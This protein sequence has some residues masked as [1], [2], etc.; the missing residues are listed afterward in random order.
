VGGTNR[1]SGPGRRRKARQ[2]LLRRPGCV[3]SAVGV[4]AAPV[5]RGD[6]AP[7][8]HLRSVSSVGVSVTRGGPVRRR[9]LRGAAWWC[10]SV[11]LV[12]GGVC[13][14][15][16]LSR[17]RAGRARR[18]RP[19]RCR[20]G[21]A[22]SP[23]ERVDP[24][25]VSGSYGGV[26]LH[27]FLGW[28]GMR[29]AVGVDLHAVSGADVGGRGHHVPSVAGG[30]RGVSRSGPSRRRRR[31]GR[32]SSSSSSSWLRGRLRVARWD[33]SPIPGRRGRSWW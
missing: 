15:G 25:A 19:P 12:V 7:N 28:S 20:F 9:R 17:R 11:C 4:D 31:R 26:G 8:L 13:R 24:Y 3:P 6:S 29:V 14:D 22:S 1:S 5:A 16:R 18:L 33:R 30:E 21:S 2:E 23:P 10:A 27:D 32:G